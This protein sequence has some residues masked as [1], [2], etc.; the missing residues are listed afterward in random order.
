MSFSFIQVNPATDISCLF[1]SMYTSAT[2]DLERERRSRLIAEAESVL[3]AEE[4]ERCK[5]ELEQERERCRKAEKEAHEE[6]QHRYQL[7]GGAEDTRFTMAK[8]QEWEH[9]FREAEKERDRCWN[10]LNENEGFR[11]RH[12]EALSVLS[13]LTDGRVDAALSLSRA[14][15]LRRLIS[16]GERSTIGGWIDRAEI[17]ML[18]ERTAREI[19][20]RRRAARQLSRRRGPF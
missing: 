11:L 20:R 9:R 3:L 17:A 4:L 6:M 19:A 16:N 7:E 2:E 1:E 8:A 15:K 18:A 5:D 13:D 10:R 12:Q 14:G